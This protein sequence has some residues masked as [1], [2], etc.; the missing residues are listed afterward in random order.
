MN[1]S[2]MAL[3]EMRG[4]LW[5]LP[6]ELVVEIMKYAPD[7]SCLW[8]LVNASARFKS[9]FMMAARGIIE[10]VVADIPACTQ[11][12]MQVVVNARTT[13]GFSDIG[14]VIKCISRETPCAP[15]RHQRPQALHDI[16]ELA[17]NIHAVAHACLDYYIEKT[18]HMKPQCL[19]NS[20]LETIYT[21]SSLLYSKH[22]SQSRSYQ[23][24]ETGPPSFV[25]EQKMIRLL[26]RLQTFFALQAACSEGA[27]AHWPEED[28]T[29]LETTNLSDMFDLFHGPKCRWKLRLEI[30]QFLSVVDFVTETT[31]ATKDS[32]TD[33]LRWPFMA[34]YNKGYH[35][36]CA[37]RPVPKRITISGVEQYINVDN[38]I[39][40]ISMGW[41]LWERFIQDVRYSPLRNVPFKPYR[42]YGLAFWNPTRL[43][44]LGILGMNRDELYGLRLPYKLKL[45]FTW[46]SI[47][48][49]EEDAEGITISPHFF[50]NTL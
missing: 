49:P 17:H 12:L 47:L 4:T 26:W 44:D 30:E 8:S 27:L 41:Y 13:P 23:P 36:H 31:G 38:R 24:R 25:E 20:D 22:Q 16:V 33:F 11:A 21:S 18:R 45:Y 35:S 3:H 37:P 7:F 10:A 50:L 28:R 19:D 32:L 46:R 40:E 6:A 2:N 42:R 9:I 39:E 34:I 15:W 14:D 48:T 43:K 5:H 1:A 29:H